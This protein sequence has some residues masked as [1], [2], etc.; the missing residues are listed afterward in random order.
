MSQKQLE[1]QHEWICV[2][3]ILMAWHF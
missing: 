3:I 2:K 1:E